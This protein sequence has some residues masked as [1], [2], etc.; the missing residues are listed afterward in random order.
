[1]KLVSIPGASRPTARLR[2]F[3]D[4]SG[5]STNHT[6]GDLCMGCLFCC[7]GGTFRRMVSIGFTPLSSLQVRRLRKP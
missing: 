7:R 2:R 1:M 6:Q 5:S 4:S 3:T